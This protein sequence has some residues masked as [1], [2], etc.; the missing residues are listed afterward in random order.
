MATVYELLSSRGRANGLFT[1][2]ETMTV[3]E[4]TR[5]MNRYSI[6]AVV[7]TSGG[8]VVGIFTE[9]DVL[10]RIVA[11]ERNPAA[12]TVGEVMTRNV[13]CATPETTLDEARTLMMELRIRHLPVM[14]ADGRSLGM[15]SIGDLNAQLC[16]EQEAT[17]GSLYD[18]LYGRS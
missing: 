15:V 7:V 8:N 3:L 11:Q 5:E 4:A 2:P 17:I 18:Y 1:V 9:R 14:D 10:R 12:V 16:H 6:G 13:T